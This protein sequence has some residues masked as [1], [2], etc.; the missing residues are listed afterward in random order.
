M[1]SYLLHEIC[2]KRLPSST[3]LIAVA[4]WSP[5]DRLP[6]NL[7]FLFYSGATCSGPTAS[8]CSTCDAD[9]VLNNGGS[10]PGACSGL[11]T[12]STQLYNTQ[13]LL[14]IT[15]GTS[16]GGYITDIQDDTLSSKGS[17]GTL[18]TDSSTSVLT[19]FDTSVKTGLQTS[20][21]NF[22]L[23]TMDITAY[24]MAIKVAGQY[25]STC[26]A[27]ESNTIS[28]QIGVGYPTAQ[29]GISLTAPAGGGSGGSGEY[30]GSTQYF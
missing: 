25:S 6:R 4:L 30:R 8:D 22:I 7:Y 24:K 9:L 3:Q 16:T 15:S 19:L 12:A 26:G 17:I 14:T 18:N 28:V 5:L 27:A 2:S 29:Q 13:V 11:Q 10:G 20:S 21:I 1:K 23:T